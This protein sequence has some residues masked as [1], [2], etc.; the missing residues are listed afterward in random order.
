MGQLCDN[1]II[2]SFFRSEYKL[3]DETNSYVDN[4][5]TWGGVI[6][7]MLSNEVE[8]GIERFLMTPERNEVVNFISVAYRIK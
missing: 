3:S 5:G 2:R 1:V 6:D 7:L 4:N 8:V